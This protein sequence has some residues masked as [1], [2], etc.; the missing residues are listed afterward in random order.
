VLE[1]GYHDEFTVIGDGFNVTQRL[2]ALSKQLN[3]SL[4]VSVTLLTA[5]C[6]VPALNWK[7]R[8]AVVLRRRQQPIDIAY[9]PE[10]GAPGYVAGLSQTDFQRSSVQR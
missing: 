7:R 10:A 6:R 1:S 4:V 9:L 2:E 8:N 5:A 3:A